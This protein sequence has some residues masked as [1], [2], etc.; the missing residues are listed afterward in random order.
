M[1]V[2]PCHSM[3]EA[4]GAVSEERLMSYPGDVDFNNSHSVSQSV[5]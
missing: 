3:P 4:K 2:S 1:K 5:I